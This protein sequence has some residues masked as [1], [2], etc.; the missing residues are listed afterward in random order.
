MQGSMMIPLEGGDP[1]P[2]LKTRIVVGRRP[3]CDVQ[4]EFPN[5]SAKHCELIWD[6]GRWMVKDLKS[7]NGTKVN[8][9]KVQKRML[10]PGDQL[11]IARKHHFKIHYEMQGYGAFRDDEE[12]DQDENVMKKSLLEK[13]GL[14][15]GKHKFDVDSSPLEEEDPKKKR[16]TLDD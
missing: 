13:A 6:K 5:I 4:L 2:L 8:G 7:A 12:D 9:E 10:V 11:T 14:E 16:R 3:D 1:I 15:K